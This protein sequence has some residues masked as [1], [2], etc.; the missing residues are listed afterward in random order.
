MNQSVSSFLI[1]QIGYQGPSLLVYLFAIVI[2]FVFLD[3]ART[4]SLLTLAAAG[5]LLLSTLAIAAL[6]AALLVSLQNG[7][8]DPTTFGQ[9]MQI[10][11]ITGACIRAAGLALLV[12]AIFVG[13]GP[14]EQAPH[15]PRESG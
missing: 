2:S 8:R 12:V 5:G 9:L 3:R 14:V 4:A 6:Q 1:S 11:G 15:W 10:I 7:G 13:R